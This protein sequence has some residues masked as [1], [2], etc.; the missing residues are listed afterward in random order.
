MFPCWL[1][2]FQARLSPQALVSS[3]ARTQSTT[4]VQLRMR[5]PDNVEKP[6]YIQTRSGPQMTVRSR[7]PSFLE[8]TPTQKEINIHLHC[9]SQVAVTVFSPLLSNM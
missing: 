4:T 5:P 8:Y 1:V 3:C 9:I 6:N 2:S 7:V